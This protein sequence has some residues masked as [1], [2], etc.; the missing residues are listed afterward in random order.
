MAFHTKIVI[1]SQICLWW[2]FVLQ[3]SKRES[4]WLKFGYYSLS[5]FSNITNNDV[6]YTEKYNLMAVKL[7]VK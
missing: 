4:F 1:A 3:L 6:N 2:I 5:H 7:N